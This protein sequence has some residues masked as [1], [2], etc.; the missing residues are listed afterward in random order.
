MERFLILLF[1]FYLCSIFSI[2]VILSSCYKDEDTPCTET[3][4]Y[5]DV[6]ND[7]LGNPDVS[8]SACNQP[9]G[10]VSNNDDTDDNMSTATS[11]TGTASITQGFATTTTNNLYPAGQRIA[12]LGS[13]TATDNS[14]WV[15]PAEVNYKD[16]SFPLAPDL[17]NP[18]GTQYS[19]ASAALAA[20]DDNDIIEI[21]PNGEV[22]TGYIFADNYFELYING[23]AVGKD[24]IPFTQFNSHIVKFKVS[25]PYTIAMLLVDWEENLGLGTEVNQGSSYHPGDGGMVAVFKDVAGNTVETTGSEWKAQTFYT[26]PIKDLTCPIENGTTRSTANCNTN[27]ENDGSNFYGL[28]WEIPSNW[29]NE[30][31]DDTTWPAATTYTNE[32]IVVNNKP[33]YTNFTDIFDDVANDAEFIWST[34][35]ILD[36]EVIVR[37]T[38]E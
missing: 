15:V 17:F 33:S 27:A 13:I 11:Y 2:T 38:V 5:Q 25:T 9:T 16:S 35:V 7:G 6:D 30:D 26:A 24:A 12:R 1:P 4:W 19:T 29:M 3:I 22:I 10:Y 32:T 20:F 31:F 18:D 37:Y 36:N 21:D 8:Q 34:N 14:V 23:T 28:H